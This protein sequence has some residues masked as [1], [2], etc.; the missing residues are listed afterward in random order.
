MPGGR[1]GWPLAPVVRSN[2]HSGAVGALD[3]PL[4]PVVRSN[5]HSGAVGAPDGPLTWVEVGQV[6]LDMPPSSGRIAPM[7]QPTTEMTIE[8]RRV[9][10]KKPSEVRPR[11]NTPDNHTEN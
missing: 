1:A 8:A 4:A 6:V 11:S 3:G 10:Q 2:V 5:V 7:I 9:S